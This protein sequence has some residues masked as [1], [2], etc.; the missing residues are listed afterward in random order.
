MTSYDRLT[1][2]GNRCRFVCVFIIVPAD[3]QGVLHRFTVRG[4][5]VIALAT[6]SL[7]SKVTW[8]QSQ[9]IAR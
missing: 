1:R 6:K 9:R 5:R 7:D 4:L 3:F 2:Q 8:V